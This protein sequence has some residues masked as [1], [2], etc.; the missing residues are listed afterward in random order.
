MTRTI[1][2]EYLASENVLKLSGP[3]E[4]IRDHARLSLEIVS[5]T[6]ATASQPWL[7]MQ[8]SLSAEEGRDLAHRIREA[9][10]RDEIEV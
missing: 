3:L 6:S 2:A 10:G 5:G 8:G 9:F 7:A 4:G 1:E